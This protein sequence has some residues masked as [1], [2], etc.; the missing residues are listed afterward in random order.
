MFDEKEE[1]PNSFGP[2]YNWKC[3]REGCRKEISAWTE[4]GLRALREPHVAEHASKD[5]E[6]LILFQKTILDGPPR[7]YNKWELTVADKAFLRTR[8]ISDA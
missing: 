1:K 7:D 4:N 3:P 8:G 2:K 6:N 5:R